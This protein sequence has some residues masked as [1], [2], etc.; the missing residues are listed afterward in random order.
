M[1]RIISTILI[2]VLLLGAILTLV[3]C[4]GGIDN[5]TYV[6]GK[7][8]VEI[9]GSEFIITTEEDGELTYTYEIKN[10]EA[11]S[12]KQKIFLTGSD[13]KTHEYYY[14]RLEEGFKFNGITYTKR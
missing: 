9:S 13:G 5:G 2:C 4:G 7:S 11:D 10:D 14:V 8:V 12:S 3:S 6:S 1:K